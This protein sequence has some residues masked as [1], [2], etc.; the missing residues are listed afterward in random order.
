MGIEQKH[1]VAAH[2][3]VH[4]IK[5]IDIDPDH[6]E[7]KE[8]EEFRSAKERLKSDGHYHCYICKGTENLQSHHMAGEYKF[9]TIV[10]FD[11]LKDFLMEW[12]CYGYSRL[13]RNL[14]ITTVDDIR[15]QLIL[16]QEHH[17]GVDHE[18]GSGAIGIHYLP[19]PEWIMQKL[20]LPGC[21]P[22]PQKGETIEQAL[23]RVKANERKDLS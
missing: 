20:C 21:N 6:G 13:M 7:R 1:I 12:D 4:T 16:C 23:A 8:S 22:I 14:P 11:L 9:R 18:D 10:D 15:N 2:A 19:F 3:E 5:V 17:T